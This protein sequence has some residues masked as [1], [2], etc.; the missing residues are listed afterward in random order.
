MSLISGHA[1]PDDT[2]GYAARIEGAASGH[3][4]RAQGYTVSS[5]GIGTYLGEPTPVYDAGY[6][7]AIVEAVGLGCNVVDTASNYRFQRSERSVGGAL[8]QLAEA[9]T[10]REQIVV[11]SKAGFITYETDHPVDPRRWV[12][13]NLINPGIVSGGDIAAGCHCMTPD[14][15]RH[16]LSQSLKNTGLECLDVYYVHNPET[17][18]AE[19]DEKEFYARLTRAFEALEQEVAAGRIRYYGT[20][21]WD[22]YRVEPGVQNAVSLERVVAAA[23]A[24]SGGAN[25]HMR[26]VQL[27]VNLVSHEALAAANQRVGTETVSL[28]QA[29]DY[30]GVSVMASGSIMQGKLAG[31]LA[32]WIE[33]V[34]PGLADDATRAIQFVRSVPGLTSAL[35]GMSRAAHVR[36]NLELVKVAPLTEEQFSRMFQQ[37]R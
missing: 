13:E 33:Q 11:C 29:A 2:A 16:Q 15:L 6:T 1:T 35:V 32:A 27:P 18:L 24:A 37:A 14:F 28:L 20:A 23:T 34:I 30:F 4:R 7:E 10:P 8:R 3:F 12:A 5:I 21:T 17:Q 36:R 9:G 22:A 31:G 26:F 19:V 25:H